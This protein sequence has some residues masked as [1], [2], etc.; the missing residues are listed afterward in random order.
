MRELLFTKT[1]RIRARQLG[2]K[3]YCKANGDPELTRKIASEN[4]REVGNPLVLLAIGVMILQAIY[5]AALIWNQLNLTIP[6]PVPIPNE[7]F[8]LAADEPYALTKTEL[9]QMLKGNL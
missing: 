7:G 4:L 6:P 3:S 5:Y 9:E 2:I 1:Y 8:K